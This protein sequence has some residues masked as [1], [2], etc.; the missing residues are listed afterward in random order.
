[1]RLYT[2]INRVTLSCL[3]ALLL[4]GCGASKKT[5]I[6]SKNENVPADAPLSSH[7]DY[8][9][10]HYPDWKDV[11]V[12]ISV[13]VSAPSQLKV[14][15]KA[16]LVKN[17]SIDLSLR[18]FGMEMGRMLVTQ[19]SIYAMVKPNKIYLQESLKDFL[20]SYTFN[21]ANLQQ[22]L[23]GEIFL[24]GATQVTPTD[25]SQF[26]ME[27]F[28]DGWTAVPKKQPK[29]VEYGFMIDIADNLRRLAGGNDRGQFAVDYTPYT[30][31]NTAGGLAESTAISVTWGKNNIAGELRWRWDS[32][33]WNQG[34][35]STWTTPKG[36]KRVRASELMKSALNQ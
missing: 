11:S 32:A 20:S 13:S 7:F 27:G 33:R 14:S 30:S 31:D 22:L 15:G 9:V 2:V 6:I 34:I 8:I 1:M 21:V 17:Q 25:A 23:L 24:A 29:G 19:D 28:S 36:F 35:S 16:T 26:R 10:T 12:N 5:S 3:I 18:V 4:A